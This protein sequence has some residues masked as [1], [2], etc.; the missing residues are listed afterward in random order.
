MSEKKEEKKRRKLYKKI[1]KKY[2][3]GKKI[4]ES[5]YKP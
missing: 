4:D 1:A 3:K 2:F 5:W